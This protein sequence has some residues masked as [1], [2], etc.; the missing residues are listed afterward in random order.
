MTR[1]LG[2]LKRPCKLECLDAG[3]ARDPDAHADL[4]CPGAQ[5]RRTH[6]EPATPPTDPTSPCPADA[7][8]RGFPESTSATVTSLP[9]GPTSK[10]RQ[11]FYLPRVSLHHSFGSRRSA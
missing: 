8:S 4:D 1:L 3:C 9:R 6:A 10:V 5:P 2:M 11:G 7:K